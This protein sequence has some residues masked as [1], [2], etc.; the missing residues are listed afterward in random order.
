MDEDDIITDKVFMAEVEHGGE[1][2]SG[3]GGVED[4]AVAPGGGA[5]GIKRGGGGD[6]V[7]FADIVVIDLGFGDG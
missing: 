6:G 5:D 2:F 3:I 1:G 4:E 7:A